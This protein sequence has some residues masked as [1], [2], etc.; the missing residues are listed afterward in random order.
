[1]GVPKTS[2]LIKI[3]IMMQN[4]SQEPP[5][6][7][8]APNEDLKN[9]DVLCT[10]KIQIESRN[11][12]H[13]FI[14]DQWPYQNLYQEAKPQSGTSSIL[15]R[16]KCGLKGNGCSLHFQN[17]GINQNL[18]HGFIIDHW[19]YPNQY[20]DAKPQSGTHSPHLSPKSGLKGHGC[21]LHQ[22]SEY[23][24]IKDQWPYQNWDQDT[25]PQ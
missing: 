8:K 9:M 7:S 24:C 17:R 11:F 12:K 23:G 20:K 2:D 25:K 15:Q 13:G 4:P 16:T 18:Y 3:N 14:K 22:Q 5:E 6:S 1:M 21:S 10:F 19:P